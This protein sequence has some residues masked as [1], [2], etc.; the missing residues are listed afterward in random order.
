M[1][2]SAADHFYLFNMQGSVMMRL[3]SDHDHSLLGPSQVSSH[4]CPP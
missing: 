4:L 3:S 1:D 2:S